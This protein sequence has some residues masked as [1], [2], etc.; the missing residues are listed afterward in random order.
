MTFEESRKPGAA[1]IV[2]YMDDKKPSGDDL[3][4]GTDDADCD[5]NFDR[6]DDDDLSMGDLENRSTLILPQMVKALVPSLVMQLKPAMIKVVRA[7]VL[8][9]LSLSRGTRAE[10][11][12]SHPHGS[13]QNMC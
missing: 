5:S 9:I 12:V 8:P 2:N 7:P 11:D 10:I 13:L 6:E 3:T 1:D 4:S